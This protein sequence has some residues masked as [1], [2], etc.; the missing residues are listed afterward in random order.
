M[1]KKIV[2]SKFD[3]KNHVKA[4]R[5]EIAP[6]LIYSPSEN[7]KVYSFISQCVKLFD[8]IKTG[9]KD[10]IAKVEKYVIERADAIYDK[11]LDAIR[12]KRD[13]LIRIQ[14]EPFWEELTFEDVDF[15]VRE[16]APLMIFYEEQRGKIISIDAPDITLN[17][18]K[19]IWKVK[20]DPDYLYFINNNQLL[21]KIKNGE[22]VTSQ[23][24]FEIEKALSKLKPSWTIDNIQQSKD[25]V[26]FLRELVEIKGLPD[27]KEMIKWEFDKF[28]K[29]RNEHYNSEQLKFLRL[30]EQVFVRVKHIE[31][32][33][34]AE[35]PL[36]EG[37]PLDAFTKEQLETIVQKCNKLKWK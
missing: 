1:I 6:L 2:S 7:A 29:D 34:F 28:V 16:I 9:N 30:L 35:H 15:L 13:D 27:P 10:R 5:E 17:V 22:G 25:F 3:L 11:N 20:E 32:K 36:T 31:L 4:L 37:R 26:L 12:A 19:E 33:N 8:F 24:L 14:K 18:E 23:E 21:N